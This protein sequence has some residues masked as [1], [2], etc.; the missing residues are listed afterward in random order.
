MDISQYA[1]RPEEIDALSA[2]QNSILFRRHKFVTK[3][4]CNDAAANITGST[5]SPTPIQGST[6]YTVTAGTKAVQFRHSALNLEIMEQARKTYGSFVPICKSRG[7]LA[8]VHVY[9][10]DLVPGVAFSRARRQL[11]SP[12]MEERLLRTVQDFARFVYTM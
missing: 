4:E 5:V 2:A 11:V 8:E 1:V 12:G 9:E 6:S 3:E 7:M 10:M